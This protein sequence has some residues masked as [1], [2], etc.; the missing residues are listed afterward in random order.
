RGPAV[1]AAGR[2]RGAGR[3]AHRLRPKRARSPGQLEANTSATDSAVAASA[4]PRCDG[5][6]QAIITAWQNSS[7]PSTPA[8]NGAFALPSATPASNS[9]TGSTNTSSAAT[10]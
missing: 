7:R 2:A 5:S 6:D 4:K 10:K 1:D 9:T 8:Q 3:D